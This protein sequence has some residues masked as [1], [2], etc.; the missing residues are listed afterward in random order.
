[1]FVKYLQH[2]KWE[3]FVYK[4]KENEPLKKENFLPKSFYARKFS[5]ILV[6]ALADFLRNL[7]YSCRSFG[8]LL[9][10]SNLLCGKTVYTTIS[11]PG[12]TLCER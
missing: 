10:K 11:Y 9:K 5:V 2:I 8:G 4:S 1:M 6:G 12:K 7:T 3:I